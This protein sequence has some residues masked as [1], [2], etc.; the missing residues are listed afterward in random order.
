MR[1]VYTRVMIIGITGTD[2]AGKGTVV[3]YLVQKRGY[4]HYSARTLFV[5]EIEKEGIE[6]NRANMRLVANKLR[7]K[8]G[9]DMLVTHYL[10]QAKKDGR[11]DIIIDSIRTVA[12]AETLRA[13][14]GVLISVDA[15]QKIR[16]ERI[17]I[18]ASSSDHV[19][20]EAFMAHEA[21]E[22][23]DPDPNGMQKAKVMEMANYKLT[24]NTSKTALNVQ[25]ESFL[26]DFLD[27]KKEKPAG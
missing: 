4:T 26:Q 13:N 5:A 6:S 9:N 2:G 19:S 23:H 1:T 10:Q 25:I 24:N 7:A 8:L 12:E 21:M 27:N 16:Y 22:M 14:G 11:E 3:D 20:F 15:D 18:R 17:Q